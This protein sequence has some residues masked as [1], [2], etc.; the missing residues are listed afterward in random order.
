MGIRLVESRRFAESIEHYKRAQYVLPGNDSGHQLFFNIGL[1][2][3]KW[4]RLAEA[5]KYIRLA[6]I[7]EPSYDKA[8]NLLKS[9][10][11][12]LSA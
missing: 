3:A 9:I 12:R 4:G 1:A 10:D 8:V 11:E 2:Y 5:R 6:L 7:R